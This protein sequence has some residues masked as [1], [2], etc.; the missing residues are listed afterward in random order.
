MGVRRYVVCSWL[1]RAS[2]FIGRIGASQA[3]QTIVGMQYVMSSQLNE[4]NGYY[5]IVS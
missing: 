4:T 2:H 5:Y 3:S 1:A